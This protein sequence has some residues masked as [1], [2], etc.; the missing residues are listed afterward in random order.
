MEYRQLGRSDLQV[1]A[2]CLGSMTWGE[3]NSETEGFAQIDRA[4]ACG[5]NFLDTAEMYPVPPRRDTYGATE[6]IIGNYFKA[7]GDRADWVLASKVAGPGNGIDYQNA[8]GKRAK[9][10]VMPL[11]C[12]SSSGKSSRR[13]N[14][15]LHSSSAPSRLN[16]LTALG[17]LSRMVCNWSCCLRNRV[18]TAL[19]SVMSV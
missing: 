4:K 16:R 10:R 8:A 2:L 5:I 3:Q 19:R 17:M 18:S 12:T 6:R 11:G 7:R 1:S 15:L 9:S 13:P 14:S